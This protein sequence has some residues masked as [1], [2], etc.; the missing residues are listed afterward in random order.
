MLND[1]HGCAVFYLKNKF[2]KTLNFYNCLD[3]IYIVV[4]VG[5]GFAVP[6]H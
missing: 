4:D 2:T 3:D 1:A 5:D 6:L